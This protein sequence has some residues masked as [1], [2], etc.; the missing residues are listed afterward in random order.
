ML[1]EIVHFFNPSGCAPVWGLVPE[2]GVLKGEA[3]NLRGANLMMS[4]CLRGAVKN[5]LADILPKNTGGNEGYRV[6]TPHW[7]KIRYV[8]FDGSPKTNIKT[9][10]A[11]SQHLNPTTISDFAWAGRKTR[12]GLARLE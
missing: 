9:K 4:N 12:P 10:E 8:G 3:S 2:R 6:G 1:S 7:K 5:Y 11:V